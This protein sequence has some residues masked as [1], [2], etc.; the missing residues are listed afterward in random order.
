ML[1]IARKSL[2]NSW[3]KSVS[4]QLWKSEKIKSTR[5]KPVKIQIK[6]FSY[7]WSSYVI[8]FHKKH[9]TSHTHLSG[10]KVIT[11]FHLFIHI[12]YSAQFKYVD[13]LAFMRNFLRLK[14]F[15]IYLVCFCIFSLF[16]LFT[17]SWYHNRHTH[18]HTLSL[19]KNK[20]NKGNKIYV[21]F[22]AYFKSKN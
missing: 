1:K 4:N 8:L 17:I 21:T 11:P 15:F 6:F 2:K 19:H 9:N 10:R 3:K 5:H 22:Y 12:F 16:H 7:T 13:I 18:M 20:K 14:R